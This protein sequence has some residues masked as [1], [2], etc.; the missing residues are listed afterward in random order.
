MYCKRMGEYPYPTTCAHFTQAP[1]DAWRGVWHSVRPDPT[2]D[3]YQCYPCAFAVMVHLIT[4]RYRAATR[5]AEQGHVSADEVLT[6]SVS[7]PYVALIP[8]LRLTTWCFAHGATGT[9]AFSVLCKKRN[10][11]FARWLVA[12]GATP[13]AWT[14]ASPGYAYRTNTVPNYRIRQQAKLA[15]HVGYPMYRGLLLD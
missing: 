9:E 7:A 13:T 2:V 11:W 5:L 8:R 1:E 15:R 14:Y 6:L 10:F 3:D 12:H 4:R